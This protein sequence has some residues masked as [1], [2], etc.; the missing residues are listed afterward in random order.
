MLQCPECRRLYA[1]DGPLTCAVDAGILTPYVDDAAGAPSPVEEAATPAARLTA[2][3][4][5]TT[6]D[7]GPSRVLLT[8]GAQEF[9]LPVG[10][11]IVL[12]R[13]PRLPTA[14]ALA[15]HDNVS[16]IHAQIDH[17]PE[18]IV[19]TDLGSTNGTRIAGHRLT[20]QM[21]TPV[22]NDAITL[23]SDVVVSIER[24]PS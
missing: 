4:A 19:V 7:R 17:G 18:G 14:A 13:D 20:P 12:G 23:A 8:I 11:R 22:H 10:E 15:A 24:R 6:L 3:V 2:D 5:S 1:D 9:S 21:P 16:R